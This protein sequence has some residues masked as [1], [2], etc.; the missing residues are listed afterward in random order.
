M[1]VN[2]PAMTPLLRVVSLGGG[3]GAPA[4]DAARVS[5]ALMAL[6]AAQ[7]PRLRAVR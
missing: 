4:L 3:H 5:E 6:L 1:S 7:R 2:I